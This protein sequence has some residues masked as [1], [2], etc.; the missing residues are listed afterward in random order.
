MALLRTYG[1]TA[2]INR[3]LNATTSRHLRPTQTPRE[4]K[5]ILHP[6]IEPK[7]SGRCFSRFQMTAGSGVP[8]GKAGLV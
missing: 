5:L 1:V 2:P 3:W 4:K 8:D 6:F 7:T